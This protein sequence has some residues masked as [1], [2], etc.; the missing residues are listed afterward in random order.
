MNENKLQTN[1][2]A[3]KKKLYAVLTVSVSSTSTL[4]L[5]FFNV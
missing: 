1:Q 5:T 2:K 3:N 4:Y